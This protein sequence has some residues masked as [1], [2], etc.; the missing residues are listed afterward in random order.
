M[1]VTVT[2]SEK[3]MEEGLLKLE[4]S[5]APVI[6]FLKLSE[7]Y[8]W[9]I[10]MRSEI[11]CG[12]NSDIAQFDYFKSWETF[13]EAFKKKYND[14]INE[15]YEVNSMGGRR[16]EIIVELQISICEAQINL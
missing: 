7:G 1:I 6:S 3:E 15:I 13:R 14:L 5:L 4:K 11:H 9:D 2:T 12:R 8:I 16:A 10:E